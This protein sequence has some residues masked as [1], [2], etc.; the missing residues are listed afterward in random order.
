M[1]LLSVVLLG[2]SLAGLPG[3][4]WSARYLWPVSGPGMTLDEAVSGIRRQ[5]R[6]L[7]ADTVEEDGRPVHRIRILTNEGRVRRL[8]LDG[9]TGRP[10]RP[11]RRR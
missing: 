7:S 3:P 9:R 4:A 11:R 5:G 6:V 2:A 8:R 10:Y 1:R